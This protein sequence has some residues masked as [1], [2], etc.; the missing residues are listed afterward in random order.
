MDSKIVDNR[1]ME[2]GA[3]ESKDVGRKFIVLIMCSLG[4]YI[5]RYYM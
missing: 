2:S 5:A 1:V 4:V 3:M